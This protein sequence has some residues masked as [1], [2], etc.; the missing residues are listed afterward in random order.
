ML[1]TFCNTARLANEAPCPQ[2]GAPSPLIAG[3]NGTYGNMG[4][5][6]PS[7]LMWGSPPLPSSNVQVNNQAQQVLPQTPQVQQ[8]STLPVPYQPQQALSTMPQGALG[9]MET[10]AILPIPAQNLS[11]LVATLPEEAGTIYVPPMYTKPRPL[12]PRYRIISG[13]LSVLI[14]TILVC[15]GTGYYVKA[16]GKLAG[17]GQLYGVIP[18]PNVTPMATAPL[19]DPPTTQQTGPAYGIINSATTTSRINSQHVAQQQDTVFKPGQPIYLT[20]SV[21]NP[22]APGVVTI[23]WFTN[24]LFYQSSTTRTIAGAITGYTEE[25][26]VQPAEGKVELYWNEQLAIR[27]YFVVR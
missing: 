12:I 25:V 20:Y 19:R 27:L 6:V 8:Q 10:T 22:K 5:P 14:V 11:A 18:P 2:C 15:A 26:Y 23:K 24:G 9:G 1:C 3:A 21:Q 13:L 7:P 4:A 17:L 16:S